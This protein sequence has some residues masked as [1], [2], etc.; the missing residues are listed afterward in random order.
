[1]KAI[2][3]EYKIELADNGVVVREREHG[4]DESEAT[5]LVKEYEKNIDNLS[6]DKSVI[7]M[8][9]GDVWRKIL[10]LVDASDATR[11]KMDITIMTEE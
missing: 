9:G 6:A 4:D 8:F 5:I 10:F 3:T 7:D 2:A 1:M 11:L